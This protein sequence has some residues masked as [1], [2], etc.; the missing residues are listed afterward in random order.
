MTSTNYLFRFEH[1]RRERLNKCDINSYK[2]RKTYQFKTQMKKALDYQ[3]ESACKDHLA[4][5]HLGFPKKIF[6]IFTARQH[7]LLC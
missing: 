2:C 5:P 6:A 3:L 4:E 7:S 1:I